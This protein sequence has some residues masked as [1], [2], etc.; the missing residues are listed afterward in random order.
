VTK[1]ID[2]SPWVF[3]LCTTLQHGRFHHTF[4]ESVTLSALRHV[5]QRPLQSAMAVL[6]PRLRM[7][8]S[9]VCS[10]WLTVAPQ[11]HQPYNPTR[12]MGHF[13]GTANTHLWRRDV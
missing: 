3:G 13:G 8:V 12:V 6:V 5:A 11:W 9:F 1:D 4:S 10:I 2:I 7:P